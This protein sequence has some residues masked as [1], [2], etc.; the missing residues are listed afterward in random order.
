MTVTP[1]TEPHTRASDPARHRHR[2]HSPPPRRS[3]ALALGVIFLL[4]TAALAAAVL[5]RPARPV[6]QSVDDS[7]LRWMGGPHDG[8]YAA[9]AAVLNWLGGPLGVVVPV[10][11]LVFLSVR[12]RWQSLLCLLTVYAVGNL[13]VVQALKF[14]VDRP[15][16]ADPLVRVDHGSFPSG[17]VA[18]TALLVVVVGVLFVP[19]AGRR[20][21]WAAGAA[22][23]V[24]MM[25]SRTWLHAH[26]LSDTL[27]GATTGAGAALL[28]W[29]LFTPLLLREAEARRAASGEPPGHE[30]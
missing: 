22:L 14:W 23:T 6:F 17:H 1:A 15:R 9:V 7:W 11:L 30:D 2:H 19:A 20:V 21:W 13:L 18:G 27:A 12:K 16:P 28:L 4:V 24:A 25:W 10:G 3:G 8:P 5:A 26:W 29:W